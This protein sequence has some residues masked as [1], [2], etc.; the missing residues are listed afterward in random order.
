MDFWVIEA[1][2][3]RN[4]LPVLAGDNY[5]D[6]LSNLVTNLAKSGKNVYLGIESD[7]GI[8]T[9]L[10]SDKVY[11]TAASGLESEVSNS[12]FLKILQRNAMNIGKSGD[13]QYVTIESGESV[14][15]KDGP[16]MCALWN[17]LLLLDD[18][19]EK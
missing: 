4:N 6:N 15:V 11:F 12:D 18:C 13:F 2:V 3:K 1:R 17:T 7:D 5:R 19:Q 14:W 10:G 9:L 16:T 8:Y